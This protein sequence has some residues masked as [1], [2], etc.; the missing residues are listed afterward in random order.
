MVVEPR[1][2]RAVELVEEQGVGRVAGLEHEDRRRRHGRA[3]D[4]AEGDRA[5][6]V[7]DEGPGEDAR[8]NR[9]AR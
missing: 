4:E 9:P 8:R 7:L 1:L 5:P 2:T 3:E 6:A